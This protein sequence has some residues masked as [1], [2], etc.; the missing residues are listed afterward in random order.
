MIN[1]INNSIEAVLN[2]GLIKVELLKNKDYAEVNIIDNGYGIP[3]N[4]HDKIF[5][6]FFSTKVNKK[7]TGLG[8]S[9][10][11]NIVEEHGGLI[12]LSSKGVKKTCFTVHFPL[13]ASFSN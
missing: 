9:I 7:N 12:A 13:S 10:C 5:N 1:L 11:K 4:I 3:E 2:G 8:L 6:P